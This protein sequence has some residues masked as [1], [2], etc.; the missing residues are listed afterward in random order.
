MK[1][2]GV[3]GGLGP[4]ATMDFTARVHRLAQTRLEQRFNTGYPPLVVMYLRD[5]PV[6]LD[7]E[8]QPRQPLEPDPQFLKL[9][10]EL[11][12]VSDFIA[13][14]SNAAHLLRAHI[15]SAA[16]RPVLNMIE[17]ALQEVEQRGWDHV[18]VLGLGDP[19]VYTR[20][21]NRLN[22][23]YETL[24]E[25]RQEAL[26][27]A[28]FAVME[29]KD[30]AQSTRAAEDGVAALRLREVDGVILGCTEIPLLLGP[31]ANEPDL[32]DPMDYLVEACL[33]AALS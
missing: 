32:L 7:E 28:I 21:F 10:S 30:S 26:D 15:E 16:G 5:P 23:R 12:R 17:L 1:T 13:I 14:P 31:A 18:G 29:G 2:I 33:Q 3:L 19:V 11:G 20:E 8:D 27:Q 24:D 9:A 6:L 4:Q 22:A 25:Q